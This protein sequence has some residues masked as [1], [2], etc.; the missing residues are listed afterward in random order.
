MKGVSECSDPGLVVDPVV[1]DL[2]EMVPV[3]PVSAVLASSVWGPDAGPGVA[4]SDALLVR[5]L[6]PPPDHSDPPGGDAMPESLP[7]PPRFTDAR[8]P[9]S[10]D[11]TEGAPQGD[12]VR[13]HP[14]LGLDFLALFTVLVV[15]VNGLRFF[16]SRVVVPRHSPPPVGPPA[17]KRPYSPVT[18]RASGFFAR[19]SSTDPHRA[20]RPPRAP[21]GSATHSRVS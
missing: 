14:V 4:G 2:Y 13:V 1:V 20:P 17:Q 12:E 5:S 18:M 9:E 21:Q 8:V 6:L 10:A 16:R 19:T 3:A 7:A 15:V 11:L